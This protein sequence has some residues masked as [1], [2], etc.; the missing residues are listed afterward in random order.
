MGAGQLVSPGYSVHEECSVCAHVLS[1]FKGKK[2]VEIH[3]ALLPRQG[4]P[5]VKTRKFVVKE[6]APFLIKTMMKVFQEVGL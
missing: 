2:R 5:V 3:L 1:F 4:C 6:Y